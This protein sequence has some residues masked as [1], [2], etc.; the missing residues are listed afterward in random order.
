M[1]RVQV[2]V[3]VA[4]TVARLRRTWRSLVYE[5]CQLVL[6][7]LVVALGF[8]YDTE[9]TTTPYR[10]FMLIYLLCSCASAPLPLP[11]TPFSPFSALFQPLSSPFQPFQPLSSPFPALFSPSSP[12]PL[13]LRVVT[14]TH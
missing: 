14:K 11:S 12:P 3:L 9:T 1:V 8:I 10:S 5:H 6:V 13:P 4:H 7:S 2:Q